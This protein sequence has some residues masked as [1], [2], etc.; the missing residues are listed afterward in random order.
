MT[1][2]RNEP[3]VMQAADPKLRNPLIRE[4]S[5]C[6]AMSAFSVALGGKADITCCTAYVRL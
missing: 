1:P 6:A 4:G 5:D 2:A 3:S